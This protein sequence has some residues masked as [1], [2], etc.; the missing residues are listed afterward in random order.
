LTFSILSFIIVEYCVLSF[1]KKWTTFVD[2]LWT[3]WKEVLDMSTIEKRFNKNGEIIGYRIRVFLGVDEHKKQIRRTITIE[4][5]DGLTPRKE[6][7]EVQRIADAWEQEQREE[8]ERTKAKITKLTPSVKSR[9]TLDDF[10][11][12]Q[13]MAKHVKDGKHTPSTVAFYQSMSD[14]IKAYFKDERAGIKLSEIGKEEVLDYL[15]FLRTT[16]DTKSGKSYGAT[17][18]QHHFNTLRNIL[19]YA[20]YLEYIKEDPCRKLKESDKP[21]KEDQ[22]VDFLDEDDAIRF[23]SCI[24]S[25]EE[26]E[27]WKKLGQSHLFWKCLIN[28]LILTG[29]RRGELVGLQW[30]DL[31]EKNAMF[32]VRR[33]VTIDTSKKEE[34]DSAKKIHVGETKGKKIRKVPISS[35]LLGLL[36]EF[37]VEQNEKFKKQLKETDY[38]FCRSENKELPIYPTEPTRLVK[39]F[40]KRHGLADVSPHDLRHTAATLAIESGA[41]I[42]EVQKLLGHKDASTTLKFY[43]GITEKTQRKTVDGIEGLLRPKKETV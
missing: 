15:T 16:K 22:E 6:E 27:Y 42:K 17:T 23:L 43:T 8:Y 21:K 30:Q 7:K 39:K 18:I 4:R 29:L 38:I 10:I 41:S 3:G 37:K 33:N 25:E 40:N 31:D 34:K 19:G 32:H 13:W 9:T 12:N 11:D 35:Y 2:N 28:T 1:R 5:P 24:D 20:V 36:Q 26:Q 14:D